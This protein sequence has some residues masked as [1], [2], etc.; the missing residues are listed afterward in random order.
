MITKA[1][2]ERIKDILVDHVYDY[3]YNE[4]VQK[5][6]GDG[7][8]LEYED[9]KLLEESSMK[10]LV[11]QILKSTKIKGYY[12]IRET[13]YCKII[14]DD[15]LIHSSLSRKLKFSGFKKSKNLEK[16]IIKAAD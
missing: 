11:D 8:K 7:I 16:N 1:K 12:E 2:K 4:K 10:I 5:L 13:E 6:E 15:R 9:P 3:C 14:S